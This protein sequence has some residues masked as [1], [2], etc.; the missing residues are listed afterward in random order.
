[1]LNRRHTDERL[2]GWA[3]NLLGRC[4]SLALNHHETTHL[5]EPDDI[6]AKVT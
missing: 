3:T 5:I 4:V 6:D 1:M 2:H